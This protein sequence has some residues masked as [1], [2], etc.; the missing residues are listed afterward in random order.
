MAPQQPADSATLGE[1]FLRYHKFN[2]RSNL[3]SHDQCLEELPSVHFDIPDILI[4]S[5][6][7]FFTFSVFSHSFFLFF[8]VWG[9][10]QNFLFLTQP[11]S[12]AISCAKRSFL[13]AANG[14][15]YIN[16]NHQSHPLF[17]VFRLFFLPSFKHTA[18][19]IDEQQLV[20]VHRGIQRLQDRLER[21]GAAL[22]V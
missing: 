3:P 5:C 19:F 12:H 18:P 21:A 4:D 10:S 17:L 2:Q 9:P 13:T 11:C 7:L 8:R 22:V 15:S 14:Y 1:G 6:Y 20:S 16:L